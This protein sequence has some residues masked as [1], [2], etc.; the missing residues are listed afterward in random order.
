MLVGACYTLYKMRKNLI[1]GIKRGVADV[2][3]SATREVAR[4]APSRTSRSRSSSS[5]S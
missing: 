4:T 2:K 1:L 3:K 5:A